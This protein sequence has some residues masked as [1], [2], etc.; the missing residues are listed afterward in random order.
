MGT[1]TSGRKAVPPAA[2][3]CAAMGKDGKQRLLIAAVPPEMAAAL[4]AYAMDEE[5]FAL[6]AS[7][8]FHMASRTGF[9]LYPSSVKVYSTLGGTSA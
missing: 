6:Y 7:P 5:L 8:Q 4:C 9:R 2:G 3:R 1:R